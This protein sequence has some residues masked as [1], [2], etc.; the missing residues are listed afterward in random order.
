MDNEINLKTNL[1][2]EDNLT[3]KVEAETTTKGKLEEEQQLK[4]NLTNTNS[5]KGNLAPEVFINGSKLNIEQEYIGFL[6]AFKG[7]KGNTGEKGDT[8]ENGKSTLDIFREMTNNPLATEK[9]MMDFIIKS[10]G[11]YN[12]N[13]PVTNSIGGISAGETFE[14][15]TIIQVLDKLLYGNPSGQEPTRFPVYYGLAT[16]DEI[17]NKTFTKQDFKMINTDRRKMSLVY[18]EMP[19]NYYALMVFPVELFSVNEPRL[20]VNGFIGGFSSCEINFEGETVVAYKTNQHGLGAL[21]ID[22]L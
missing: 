2:T 3:G 20:G 1:T 22:V 15:H 10:C 21:I 11:K 14:N 4:G 8:G 12:R 6:N 7:E 16:Q 17:E 13:L 9:D 18:D 5:I 19:D